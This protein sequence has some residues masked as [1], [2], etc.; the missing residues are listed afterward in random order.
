MTLELQPTLRGELVNLRPLR[1]TDFPALFAVACDPLIWEQHP[2]SDRYQEPV[3]RKFFDDGI[4]SGG[5]LLIE[6]AKTQAVIGSSRYAGY[7]PAA[8]EVEIGWTFLSRTHW[9]GPCNAAVKSLML[10][11]AFEAVDVVVFNV[12]AQNMRSQKAVLKLGAI[13]EGPITVGGTPGVCF[14]LSRAAY[15]GR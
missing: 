11:H 10:A 8:S 13:L 4:A 3:F 5:A 2:A 12:G 7:S 14:R 9:G 1:T 15:M 6:D